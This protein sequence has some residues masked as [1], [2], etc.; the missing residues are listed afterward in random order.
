MSWVAAGIASG[1]AT[2]AGVQYLKG[3]RD[4]AKDAKKRPEYEIPQEV[5]QNLTQAQMDALQGLPA[6]QAQQFIQNIQRGSAFGMS[7]LGSRKAGL[8]GLAALN[9]QQQD[10]YGNLLSIDAQAA[11]QNKANLMNQRQVMAD[12][13][14]Q[15][16][17]LNKINPYYE[18][19]ARREARTAALFQ[20]LNN[21]ATMGMGNIGGGGGGKSQ[22]QIQTPNI[23]DNKS[24]YNPQG[25]NNS[26]KYVPDGMYGS[27]PGQNIG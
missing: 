26:G 11:Q 9:Q 6:A 15:A 3:K 19:I 5:A 14:D 17:Q 18:N 1:A 24:Y 8:A 23:M 4:Q 20:N 25:N 13:R 2:M 22:S 10:A 16:F 21:A 12:Y 27:Y 7:Q